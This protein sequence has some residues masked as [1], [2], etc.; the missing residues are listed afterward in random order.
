[1]LFYE[2]NSFNEKNMLL[3]EEVSIIFYKFAA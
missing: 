3:L 1:M 2:E